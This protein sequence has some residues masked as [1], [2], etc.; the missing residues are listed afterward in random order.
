MDQPTSNPLASAVLITWKRNAEYALRLVEDL[1]PE[2]WVAQPVAG[3]TMNHPAW[4]F[5]HLNL[6]AAIG[7]CL[8]EGAP[9]DDPADHP[10]GQKSQLM[11]AWHALHDRGAAALEVCTPAITSAPNPLPRWRAM[12]PTVGDMLVTLM[13]KHESAHLGQ[14]SAWRRAMGLGRVA[15]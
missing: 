15:V 12:H 8:A 7:A 10:H 5:S 4:V 13:V 11:T 1:P 6:Y 3:R 14:L 2:A 9:F